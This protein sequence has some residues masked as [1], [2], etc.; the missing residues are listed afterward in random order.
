MTAAHHASRN[1]EVRPAAPATSAV[2]PRALAQPRRALPCGGDRRRS[3]PARSLRRAAAVRTLVCW[4]CALLVPA[5][6][7]VRRSRRPATTSRRATTST[8]TSTGTRA[9]STS[10]P[11]STCA[12]PA[13]GAVDRLELNTVAAKL[14]NL[15]NLR[16]RVD[17]SGV[18]ASTI[19]PDH[20]RAAAASG[21]AAGEPR[22][23]S[24]VLPGA[25]RRPPP[26]AGPTS[27]PSSTAWPSCTASSPGSAAG[28]PSARSNHGEPFVTPVSPRV[29]V[30]VS[31]DRKLVWATSGRQ[32]QE[33]RAH[34]RSA[35]WPRTCATSTSPPAPPGTTVAGHA[36]RTARP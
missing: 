30:T 13:V 18:S 28:S 16:V 23:C 14:G 22:P 34:G 7:V 2:G 35:T 33:A 5:A 3:L 4:C 24:W 6:S 8:S 11:P 26:A 36:R 17:G 32:H 29:E 12:T 27:S 20:H 31:S 21:L 1:C 9:G 10:R 25:P 19:G 15:K